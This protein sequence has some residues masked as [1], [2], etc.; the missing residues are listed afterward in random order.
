MAQIRVGATFVLSGTKYEV[1]DVTKDMVACSDYNKAW[2]TYFTP[3]LVA[4]AIAKAEVDE[5]DGA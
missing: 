5:H 4:S 2:I 3:S 1:I